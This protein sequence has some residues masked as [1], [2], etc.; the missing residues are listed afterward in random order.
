M[1]EATKKK[2]LSGA[3]VCLAREGHR[4]STI[5]RISEYAGVNHGLLHHYFGSKEELMVALLEQQTNHMLKELFQD[6]PHWLEKL[7]KGER[8]LEL[9]Q[10][11]HE[12]LLKQSFE[13]LEKRFFSLHDDFSRV[14]IE[15]LSM[16]EEM[17]R[18]AAKLREV[19]RERR[20]LLGLYFD[21]DNPGLPTL[22]L[23]AMMGL[24]FHYRLDP[25]IAVE[26]ARDLL[27]DQ[28]FHNSIKP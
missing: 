12:E 16:S 7:R 17:P 13:S 27:R 22:L 21:S 26:Q 8:P 4:R 18:V 20:H 3:R 25:E 10:M 5:K 14:I 23:G 2:I 11:E 28:L 19:F 9:Q 24:L 15:F 6:Q 1:S